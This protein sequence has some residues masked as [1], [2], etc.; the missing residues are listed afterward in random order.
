ME[1]KVKLF[2]HPVHPMLIVF[3]LGLLI[4]AT[5]IDVLFLLTR[6]DLFPIVSFYNIVGGVTGGVLAAIFGLVDF[7][8]IP[9]NTRAK[10]IGFWHGVGNGMVILLFSFSMLIRANQQGFVPGTLALLTSFM[11]IAIGSITAWMGGELVN[12]LGVG[13]DKGANVNAPSSLITKE[14]TPVHIEQVPVTGQ[15]RELMDPTDPRAEQDE[16]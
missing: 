16:P 9:N 6:N 11:G 14:T 13:V 8:A 15:E 10:R 3:P 12:R 4:T 7:F 5:I 1:S 2:G